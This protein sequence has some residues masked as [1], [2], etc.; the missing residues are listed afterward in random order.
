MKTK[1]FGPGARVP[2]APIGSTNEIAN[3]IISILLFYAFRFFRTFDI[4]N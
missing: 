1:E 3:N 4:F 2:G